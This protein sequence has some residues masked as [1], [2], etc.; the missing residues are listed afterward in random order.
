MFT[1]LGSEDVVGLMIVNLMFNF[2]F[3]VLAHNRYGCSTIE[4]KMHSFL[5]PW[6][7]ESKSDH[8]P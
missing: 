4:S 8:I 2:S 5:F 6:M 1:K 7:K 3:L